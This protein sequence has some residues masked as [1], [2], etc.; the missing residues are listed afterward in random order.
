MAVEANGRDSATR[1]IDDKRLKYCKIIA[2]L[3][4]A[5]ATQDA[6]A[7]RSCR[8]HAGCL[9][10]QMKCAAQQNGIKTKQATYM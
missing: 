6:V 4:P 9:A 3:R 7:K 1:H 10:K 5:S 2:Q 8:Y